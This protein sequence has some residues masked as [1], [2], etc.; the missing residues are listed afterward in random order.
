MPSPI[1]YLAGSGVCS[2]DL[3]TDCASCLSYGN[4]KLGGEARAGVRLGTPRLTGSS[5]AQET[6][7]R[8]PR[9]VCGEGWAV[10]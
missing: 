3:L 4:L 5:S 2:E 10:V 6:G 9:R 8:C 7:G 1:K